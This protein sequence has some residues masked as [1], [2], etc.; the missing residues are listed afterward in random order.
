M[1]LAGGTVGTQ[2]SPG[3]SQGQITGHTHTRNG[4]DVPTNGTPH[5]ALQSSVVKPH[6]C[7]GLGS[8][9]LLGSLFTELET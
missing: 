9:G 1:R 6:P 4:T 2:H 3:P 7:V 8:L 5:T